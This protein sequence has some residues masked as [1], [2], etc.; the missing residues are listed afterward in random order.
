MTQKPEGSLT[1]RGEAKS[2]LAPD[3]AW[4]RLRLTA[5]GLTPKDALSELTNGQR[6]AETALRA[7]GIPKKALASSLASL[8]PHTE[9]ETDEKGKAKV[10][11]KGYDAQSIET[12]TLS[13]KG[14][15]YLKA[16]SHLATACPDVSLSLSFGLRNTK[17]VERQLIKAAT[18]EAVSNAKALANALS[19]SL[20]GIQS[21]TVDDVGFEPYRAEPMALMAI[22]RSAGFKPGAPQSIEVRAQVTIVYRIG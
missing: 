2:S 21:A 16:F 22:N 18:R 3:T 5:W 12:V 19:E 7:A 8:L 4:I 6:K 9:T 15:A 14:N 1:V 17:G 10:E 11:K 20:L 13:A